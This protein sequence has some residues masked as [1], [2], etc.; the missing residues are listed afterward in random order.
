MVAK[1][2]YYFRRLVAIALGLSL[3]GYSAYRSWMHSHDPIGP[4][5]A[6][7]AAIMLA[8][9]EHCW[10]HR[11]WLRFTGLFVGGAAAAILSASLVLERVASTNTTRTHSTRSA[12][13]ERTEARKALEAAQA[14]QDRVQADLLAETRNKGCGPVCRGLKQEVEAAADAVAK[15]RS[16]LV[17]LGAEASENPSVALLGSYAAALQT[18]SLLGL[19]IWLELAAP[20]VLAY[21]FGPGPKGPEPKTKRR[22]RKSKRVSK[23]KLAKNDQVISWIDEFRRRNGRDPKIPEVRGAFRGMPRTTAWRRGRSR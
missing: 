23:R 14:R 16:Q 17:A 13:L 9:A 1:I 19:P 20:L 5:A 21:G 3:T 10:R 7:G 6:A 4:L 12:N 11:H 15:A 18:G 8:S 2:A 22:R